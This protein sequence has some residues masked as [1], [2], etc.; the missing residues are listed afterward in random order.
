[1]NAAPGSA[2]SGRR[3]VTAARARLDV[4][5]DIGGTNTKL[6]LV[7]GQGR[8]VRRSIIL[9]RAGRGPRV[10]LGRIARAIESLRRGRPVRSVGVGVAGLVD[11]HTGVVRLP[12]NLPGWHGTP[13][14]DILADAL[15]LLVHCGNDVNAVTIGEWLYGAGQACRHLLCLTLGTGVG[16]GIIDDGRLLLG[17]N[18]AAAEVGHLTIF[19]NGPPCRCGGRGCLERYVGAEYI[20][21]RCRARL[22]AQA[23]RVKWHRN[24]LPMFEGYR[25]EQPSLLF[26]LT[27]RS[28]AAVDTRKIGTAA[29]QG[30][31]LA[32]K[33]VEETGHFLGL[34]IVN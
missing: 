13:V 24:Q 28:L 8:V 6:G 14:A 1:M 21:E 20:V 9:T 3:P 32:L 5:V 25:A 12:P 31:P 19:G 17:A 34:D 4:G 30:D 15:G 7:D 18:H 2:P 23:R 27:G 33:V 11:H 26:D 29:R 10:A 16:G 22:K